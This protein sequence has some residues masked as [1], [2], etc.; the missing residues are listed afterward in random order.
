MIR[1]I[2]HPLI[3]DA[4]SFIFQNNVYYHLLLSE[5][6]RRQG[7]TRDAF[8]VLMLAQRRITRSAQLHQRISDIYKEDGQYMAAHIHIQAAELLQPRYSTIKR[9][10]LE[11]DFAHWKEG[12]ETLSRILS[13]PEADIHQYLPLLNRVVVYYPEF[14]H[15]LCAI[16]DSLRSIQNDEKMHTNSCLASSIETALA[17]RWVS[18]AN[19]YFDLVMIRRVVLPSP[20]NAWYQRIRSDVGHIAQLLDTAWH[21][22]HIN[23][24]DDFFA[25]QNG[26]II[27]LNGEI[28]RTSLKIEL[29]IPTPFFSKLSDEKPTYTT[30]RGTFRTIINHLLGQPD[31]VVIPRHQLNWRHCVPRSGAPVISYH[32]HSDENTARHLHIQ[33][34]TFS[35]FCS[36]DTAGFAGFASIATDHSAIESLTAQ[37]T[38]AQLDEN[39][40][41]L[42]EAFVKQNRSKYAQRETTTPIA[43]D[44]VFVAMQIPTDIV[45]R[46]AFMDGLQLVDQVARFYAGTST[47]VVV[48]RHPYCASMSV[49]KKLEE[50]ATEGLIVRN[51]GSIHDLIA[52][53]ERVFV[54]NSGVGLEAL[55]HDKPVTVTGKCDYAYAV[56]TARSAEGLTAIMKQNPQPDLARVRRFLYYYRHHYLVAADDPDAIR[57]RIDRW[58]NGQN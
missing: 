19:N 40:K 47:K 42:Q 24:P 1:M 29:F 15:R 33:E 51:D 37:I 17:N 18:D 50:L 58:L 35:G 13:W 8:R 39:F 23:D 34:S 31:L 27:R 55:L 57:A 11:S 4:F 5:S 12:S 9:F 16:R 45:A 56:T 54:V 30:V 49:Q 26:Q 48:K 38:T 44:Y 53:A 32:T 52:H 22:E 10:T 43:G 3:M 46:L 21:N 2:K 6:F 7:N 28:A 36:L 41:S 14:N 25:Q 20:V